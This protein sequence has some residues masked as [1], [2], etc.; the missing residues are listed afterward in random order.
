MAP[1]KKA[2]IGIVLTLGEVEAKKEEIISF[3]RQLPARPWT[4]LA[5]ERFHIDRAETEWRDRTVGIPGDVSI[6]AYIQFKHGG[7][8]DVDYITPE[9]ITA[10][11]LKSNDINFLIVYDLLEAFHTDKSKKI[12]HRLKDVLH[13]ADN[14][15]PNLNFQEFVYSKLLYYNHFHQRGLPVAP[16]ITISQ[17]EWKRQIAKRGGWMPA[18]ADVLAE[19]KR[20]GFT[21]FIIKPVYGQE[22]KGCMYFELAEMCIGQ[23]RQHLKK[24]LEKYPGAIIQQYIDDF[25]THKCPEVRLYYVG[26]KYQYACIGIP[27]K[28]MYTLKEDGDV[29]AGPAGK[30][31]GWF[32]LPRSV[33]VQKLKKIALRAIDNMPPISLKRGQQNVALPNL[34][35]RVDMGCIR[36][37]VFDPWINEVEFV[38]SLYI[39]DHDSPI[40]AT[41]GDQMVK[42]TKQYLSQSGAAHG[43]GAPRQKKRMP[44][45]STFSRPM[46]KVSKIKRVL[47]A[48]QGKRSSGAVARSSHRVLKP[49][50]AKGKSRARR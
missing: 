7:A 10:E 1:S 40:D 46:L 29:G 33:D 16:T 37:G 41:M 44:F 19:M 22:A 27:G 17:E 45:S 34:L 42:I 21:D 47:S 13:K 26:K 50:F 9:E 3:R 43:K 8:F 12:F 24:L 38:P 15:F 31:S 49:Q 14:V 28:R 20:R 39:E 6:G 11:R 2:R 23:F 48:F 32:N 18:A 36:N 5:P 35:T 25:G 4:S 30:R